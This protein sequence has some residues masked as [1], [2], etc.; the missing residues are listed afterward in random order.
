[1]A[2]ASSKQQLLLGL[3]LLVKQRKIDAIH[4]L[5]GVNIL[6]RRHFDADREAFDA[7]V[8]VGA[9]GTLDANAA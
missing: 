9:F 2:T 6:M 8:K 3:P 5:V 7:E 4:D 1:L